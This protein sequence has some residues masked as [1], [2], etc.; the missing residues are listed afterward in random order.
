[1]NKDQDHLAA[2]SEGSGGAESRLRRKL[3][4]RDQ[5]IAGMKRR[6][7]ALERA[8]GARTMDLESLSRNVERAVTHAL[9]NVRMIPVSGV[10]R[11]P[12]I[13]EVKLTDAPPRRSAAASPDGTAT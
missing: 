5:K 12:K 3:E 4:K 7:I 2:A 1:M 6:I 13:L 8:L 10:G 11:D 9:C